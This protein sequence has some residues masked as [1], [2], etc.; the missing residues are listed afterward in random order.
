MCIIKEEKYICVEIDTNNNKFWNIELH[1][2]NDVI[3]KWGRVGYGTQSKMFTGEG[4]RF[5][6]SKIREKIKKGYVLQKTVSGETVYMNTHHNLAEIAK[7]QIKT[8]NTLVSQFIEKLAKENIHNIVGAT[9]I[10]Y[11]VAS[12]EFTT[13]LGIINLEGI[14]EGRRL[15]SNI[16]DSIHNK[17]TQDIVFKSH[18]NDYLKIIP[19]KMGMKMLSAQEIFPNIDSCKK[20]IDIL[21]SLESS[22]QNSVKVTNGDST[23]N[24]FNVSMDLVEDVNIIK[25]IKDKYNSTRQTR[26]QCYHLDIKNIY[27]IEIAEMKNAFS[28]CP[29]KNNIWELWHGTKLANVLSI[30]KSGLKVS[31][32]STAQIA[33]KMFG[34]GIYTSDQSTKALNYSY[35]YWNGQSNNTCYMFLCDVAMGNYYTP[36]SPHESFPKKGYDSTFA[37]ANISSVINNEMI[38]YNNS[39]I[40]LTYLVEFTP[41]GK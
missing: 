17:Q 1:D 10:Q 18:V 13:P 7:S 30:L 40:N 35:G 19:Q 36:K 21:D 27:K 12:G 31:P 2:N 20:Q 32:P 39:Q 9:N 37:K 23:S 16:M 8:K 6:E 41:N 15:I 33:G 24:I 22:L 4:S 38:V 34:N 5:F 29:V 26:H 25:R 14:T 3:T 11:N 28:Q